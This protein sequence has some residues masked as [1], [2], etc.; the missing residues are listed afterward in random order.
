MFNTI[1]LSTIYRQQDNRVNRALGRSLMMN[2]FNPAKA[3][4][5]NEKFRNS[6]VITLQQI[7]L[8]SYNRSGVVNSFADTVRQTK[9]TLQDRLNNG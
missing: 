7:K 2:S 9:V 5:T 1:P 4:I 8:S 6:D 3:P